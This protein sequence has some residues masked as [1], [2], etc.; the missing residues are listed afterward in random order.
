MPAWMLVTVSRISGNQIQVSAESTSTVWWLKKQIKSAW[1]IRASRQR[2]LV[3]ES[4]LED[5]MLLLDH[6]QCPTW[7]VLDDI[8]SPEVHM[9]KE[10]D[11]T[12]VENELVT[13]LRCHLSSPNLQHCAGC[14]AHY[15]STDCQR[16]HWSAHKGACTSTARG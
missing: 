13:C 14:F 8:L 1:S 11:V 9:Q 10:V 5:H 6:A 15:C 4:Q 12:I 3:G 7:C 2:I 16:A